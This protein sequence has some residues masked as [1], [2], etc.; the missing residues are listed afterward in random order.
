M[1][2]TLFGLLFIAVLVTGAFATT[3]TGYLYT[4]VSEPQSVSEAKGSI[5]AEG[6]TM[7]ILSLFAFGDASIANIAAQSGI[8]KINHIDKNTF[9]IYWLFARETFTVYGD[10]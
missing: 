1:R 6:S 8:K 5:K 7:S 3:T 10:K 9:T 2:R 4:G